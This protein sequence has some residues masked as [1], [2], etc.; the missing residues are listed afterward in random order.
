M[1]KRTTKKRS[2]ASKGSARLGEYRDKRDPTRT[3]EPFA[4]EH[5][6]SAGPTRS[7][8]F[9]VHLHAA[10]RTHYDLRLQIGGAL[11]SF[12]VPKGPSLDP[13]QKH[14]AVHTEV[15][16]LDYVDFEDVIPE[17]NYGAGPM[18]VWDQGGVRYLGDPAE[19]Q[20]DD[21]KL[22]FELS[23]YKLRGRFALVHT[24]RGKPDAEHNWLLIKKQD[25][26]AAPG[27]NI[28]EEQPYSVL[29]GLRVDQLVDR[30]RVAHEL[31]EAAAR[32]GAPVGDVDAARLTPM[33]C[34]DSGAGLDA[35]DRLYELK[36]DGARILAERRGAQVSLRYRNGRIAT[37]SYPEIARA[38][39][40]LA[41]S[42]VVLDGEIVAFDDEGRPML[43]R[44]M[45][46]IQARRP[47]DVRRVAA[48][49]PVV[50]VVFDVLQLGER[51][52]TRLP[53]SERK[54]LLSQVIVGS[55]LLR[56]LDHLDGD[57]RALFD[58]CR[59]RGLEGVVA[60]RRG[61]RYRP[62]PVR[63][64]DWV[65]IKCQRD[66]E[67]V[68]IGWVTG[69]GSRKRVG[70]LDLGSYAGDRLVYRGKVGSG[71]DQTTLDLLDKRLGELEV[72][73][74]AFEGEAPRES[75]TR[76]FVRPE[77]V[78]S[79][80]YLGFT[81]DGRLREPVFRALRD[82]IEPRQCTAQPAEEIVERAEQAPIEASVADSERIQVTNRDKVF[83][84]NE[85]YTKGDLCD[86]YAAI[87]PAL[88]PFL[89]SRPVVLVRYPDGIEGKNFFQWNAPPGTPEWIRTLALVDEDDSGPHDKSVFL[90]DDVDSLVH[91][92]NLGCI[93]IHVLAGREQ[94]LDECD[95][96]TID[97]DI[98]EQPFRDAVVLA[99]SLRGLLDEIGLP[100]YPKTSGQSGLHVLIPLGPGVKFEVA[101][102][103]VEL[104]GRCLQL[105]HPGISTMERRVSERGPRVY[106]DTGQTGRSR[107][108]VAPYSVR[109][110]PGATVS[111]PLGWDEVH[112][113]LDPARFSMFNVLAR[114][115]ELGDPF[116]GLLD[117]RPDVAG[118]VAR[119][120][121][122]MR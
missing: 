80:R 40:S 20:L 107:T 21:G 103:L 86:Y 29:S 16:P 54:A 109:A 61:S 112:L 26:F 48:Q 88:L 64:G 76:R 73:T 51:D 118:A 47:L 39:S 27:G 72:D 85:G 17:G 45:P 15:H 110:R 104:V 91:I 79:V 38:V 90:V 114:V 77:L 92:A 120:E 82:D 62:G 122:L 36:L 46:R 66:D 12:A 1:Q 42:H 2:H 52:L 115:A 63:S 19:K 41:S 60:K 69:K 96:L 49:V 22:D 58:F 119:L 23:G 84:P 44:L 105:R 11:E 28:I 67:F 35:A 32:L 57:G 5:R 31:E 18:I 3:N 14:L 25:A 9:V 102:I 43:Q 78:A 111:T 116:S 13:E 8:R 33:L 24:G 121:A 95:F 68:V 70:A 101:K 97:L 94:S 59:E 71:F 81:E 37:D 10:T 99:L 34:A 98:G 4:A 55:G 6:R 89:K 100:G 87:A 53:L 113:A 117:E 108:I 74:P 7:G 65:K 83:W 93:P 50:Y 30:E 106:I 75:G 56:A